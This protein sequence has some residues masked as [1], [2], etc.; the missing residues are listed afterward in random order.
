YQ[1]SFWKTGMLE[2]GIKWAMTQTNND[3]FREDSLS[4]GWVPNT[5]MS[6]EF[7][8]TEHIAAAYASVGRMLGNKWTLKLGLRG[9]FT[10]ALGNWITT[11]SETI[12]KYFNV[13]PTVFVG[14]NPSADWR[15][16]L[17][18]TSRIGRP[19]FSQLNPFRNYID[20]NSYTE[21]N[22]DLDPQLSR[23]MALSVTFK[24][25]YSLALV[26][27]NTRN[28]IM[29]NPYYDET[30]TKTLLWENFGNQFMTGGS[31]SVSELPI[32]KWLYFTLSGVCVYMGNSANPANGQSEQYINNGVLTNMQGQITLL[33]P[34]DWKIELMGMYQGKVPYGYFLIDPIFIMNGGVKKNFLDNRATLSINV[35]DFFGSLDE[36]LVYKSDDNVEYALNQSINIQI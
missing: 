15:L 1:Q 8:Y 33:L 3:L 11:H 7:L 36:N 14:Y 29:Q 19:S 24:N 35:S 31:L 12:K 21:G 9:E 30:G 18:Y 13:F 32:T 28:L 10:Y 6:N 26:Y 17:S 16:N 27:A 23:Q 22:P 20:A 34:K 25:H 4:G 5:N 2:T